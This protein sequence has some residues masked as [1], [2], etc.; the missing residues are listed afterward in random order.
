M[1][2]VMPAT[3]R[4][5]DLATYYDH[6][7]PMR[8]KRT[9]GVE[10]A[11]R[12]DEFARLLVDERRR[13]L[14]EVGTGPGRDALAFI[15]AGLAVTGVDLSAEHVRLAR[16][17]GVDALQASVL[18]LPFSARSFDAAWSMSTLLH[19]PNVLFDAAMS[20]IVRVVR[21]GSP[22]AVGLW[23]GPDSEGPNERDTIQP[24]RFF[25]IRSDE[26]VQGMLDAHGEL[27]RFDSW[28]EPGTEGLHY[29]FVLLRPRRVSAVR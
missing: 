10:R 14:L 5:R 25:S 21:P 28:T 2:L 15:S 20:E 27:E 9:V 18:D 24:P 22:I 3:E 17:V 11:R 12:R 7:A 29:Q 1:V 6:E 4:D 8:A 13:S 16:G 19:I 26:R 23:G